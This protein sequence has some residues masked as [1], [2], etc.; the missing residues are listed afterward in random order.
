MK[1]YLK[2]RTWPKGELKKKELIF[3]TKNQC[4]LNENDN[5]II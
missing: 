4:K 2:H 5:V 1:L 3:I